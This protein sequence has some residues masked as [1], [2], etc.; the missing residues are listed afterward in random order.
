MPPIVFYMSGV[1][2]WNFFAQTLTSTS[3]TFIT[4]AGIFGKVYFPRI[5]SPLAT[6][7]SKTIQFGIQLLLLLSF[8]TYYKYTGS[9]PGMNWMNLLLIPFVV[10]MMSGMGLGLGIMLSSLTTKYRDLSVLIGFGVNLLMY[11]TPV[12]YPLSSV[13]DRFRAVLGLNPLTPVIEFFRYITVG[14]GSFDAAS[15]FYSFIWMAGLCLLG[16]LLFNKVEKNV[17]DTV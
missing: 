15:L 14:V 8:V 17:M 1:T 10:L 3:N 7:L 16:L 12:I 4:N 9:L 13:S 2:I 5:V 6:V 11:L